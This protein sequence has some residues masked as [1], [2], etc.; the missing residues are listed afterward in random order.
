[1]S[2]YVA[3]TCFEHITVHGMTI[4]R[5]AFGDG[6]DTGDI[7]VCDAPDADDRPRFLAVIARNATE[8]DVAEVRTLTFVRD[9]DTMDTVAMPAFGLTVEMVLGYRL[10]DGVA[11]LPDGSGAARPWDGNG[12]PVA[13]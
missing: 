7:L 3:G 6:F 4:P 2:R 12:I 1:M 5:T 9:F 8:M 10:H 13:A 11:S